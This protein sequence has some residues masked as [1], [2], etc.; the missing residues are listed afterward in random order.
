MKTYETQIYRPQLADIDIAGVLYHANYF[1]FYERAREEL[2]R[3]GA[4]PYSKLVEA[5]SFLAIVKSQ[6]SFIRPIYIDT[7]FRVL[8]SVSSLRRASFVFDYEFCTDDGSPLHRAS[9]D[10][11]FVHRTSSGF[12]TRRIPPE[13]L[14]ILSEY[15]R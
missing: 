11:A 14:A 6:Q 8:L 5:S 7:E 13:L 12:N 2:L 10:M 4:L 9:T 1:R 15:S 3:H